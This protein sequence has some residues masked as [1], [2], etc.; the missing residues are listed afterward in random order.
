M[1]QSFCH[2]PVKEV[3]ATK[4]RTEITIE[5]RRIVLLSK[6]RPVAPAWCDGCAAQVKMVSPEEAALFAGVSSRTI[7]RRVETGQLHF[8][9]TQQGLLLICANSLSE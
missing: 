8:M 7:Y 5:R 9:E 4:R 1:K 3:N 2:P 6:R